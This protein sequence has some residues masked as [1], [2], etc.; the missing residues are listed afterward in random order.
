MKRRFKLKIHGESPRSLFLAFVLAKLNC[1]VYV[2]DFLKNSNSKK[3]TQTFL[4]S[5]SSKTLLNKFDIWNEI[6]N[7][8]Y[9]FTSLSIRDNLVSEQLL[10]RSENFSKKYLNTIGWIANYSDIKRL[11]ISK[12]INS[13]NVHF[14]S[15]KQL[16]DESL[17]FDYEFNFKNF[18]KFFKLFKFPILNLN[19]IDEQILIFNIYLRG[20]VEKRLYKINTS[21]GLLVLTPINKNLYQVIWNNASVRI[22]ETSLSSKSFFLDNLTTLLP[23]ELIVD[24]IIGDI[25]FSQRSTAF[26]T[27]LIRN[28]SIYFNE[29]KFKLNNIYNFN[30]DMIMTNILKIYDFIDKNECYKIKLLNKSGFYFLY[31]KYLEI[32]LNLSFLNTLFNL[33]TVNNFF[34]LFIRKLLFILIKKTNLLNILF[35]INTNN[36]NIDKLIIGEYEFKNIK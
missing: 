6:E 13:D 23:K 21:K 24:Q 7:I 14:I 17:I 33:F 4:F 36:L 32:V 31:R 27:C 10:L 20:H 12:L 8:S 11:L 35:I 29:N 34:S 18:D 3:D 9:E 30:F 19:K 26:Y 28:K 22:K 2:Y 5:N 15:K 1:D 25:N 16:I